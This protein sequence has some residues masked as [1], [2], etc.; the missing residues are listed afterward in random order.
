MA[1]EMLKQG[2]TIMQASVRRSLRPADLYLTYVLGPTGTARF[3]TALRQNPSAPV[4]SVA[5]RR[6]LR[7]AGLLARDGRPLS[8]RSTY[9]AIQAML[10]DH[11]ARL[12]PV[13]AMAVKKPPSD[14]QRHPDEGAAAIAAH[15]DQAHAI[16]A[17]SDPQRDAK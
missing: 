14:E 12:E 4:R 11:H 8:V 16:S 2:R 17:P 7:N 5:S 9:D 10:H 1:G 15:A 3:L 6:V 13:V